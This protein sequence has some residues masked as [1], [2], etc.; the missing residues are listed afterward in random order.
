MLRRCI[1]P[2]GD[3]KVHHSARHV[4]GPRDTP[5]FRFSRKVLL[6]SDVVISMPLLD[7]VRGAGLNRLRYE[8]RCRMTS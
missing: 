8:P 7:D 4:V 6:R 1:P 3:T 2:R 5:D